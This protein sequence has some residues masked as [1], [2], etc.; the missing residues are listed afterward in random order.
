MKSILSIYSIV[1]L[2]FFQISCGKR[3]DL[4]TPTKTAQ[5]KD[6]KKLNK[7]IL[8]KMMDRLHSKP[9]YPKK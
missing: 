8:K 9:E 4:E 2:S 5:E 3:A 7:V 1:I 6:S